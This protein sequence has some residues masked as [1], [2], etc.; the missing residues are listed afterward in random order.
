MWTW[1]N[2]TGVMQQYG[3]NDY[4]GVGDIIGNTLGGY[5]SDEFHHIHGPY[6]GYAQNRAN[7]PRT[8][9]P[10]SLP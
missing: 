6:A 9:N 5:K 2:S 8:T 4:I 7:M 3:F 1:R 10:G